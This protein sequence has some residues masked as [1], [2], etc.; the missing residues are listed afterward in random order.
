[1]RTNPPSL[2]PIFRSDLQ[3]RLLA[4]LLL[5]DDQEPTVVK[6]LV[7][8]TGGLRASVYRELKRL[9][10]AGL[11]ERARPGGYRAARDSTLYEPL[12]DLLERTLG[13]EPL[14]RRALAT[15][16]GVEVA[17]IFGSWAAGDPGT[18]SDVD[19][20]VVGDVPRDDLL[21]AVREVEQQ[22]R[23]EIDVNVYRRAD[24]DQRLEE[25]SGFLKTV[26][27]GSLIPLIGE[28]G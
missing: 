23:R 10:Q 5:R 2:L 4:A 15:V 6:S 16:G 25:G 19:L 26:L 9:E 7:E 1:M 24:F 11:V 18:D 20:L 3:A 12:H 27:G 14:L 17:A 8:Q 21:T 22:T 28:V 13:V